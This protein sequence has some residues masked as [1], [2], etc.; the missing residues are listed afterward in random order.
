MEIA[1]SEGFKG[2]A[3]WVGIAFLIIAI[4]FAYRSFYKMRIK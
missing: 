4:I 2:I 1:I 3:P